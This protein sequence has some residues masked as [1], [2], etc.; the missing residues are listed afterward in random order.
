MEK[1]VMGK[2]A[3][4]G[5]TASAR[6]PSTRGL[7]FELEY[8]AVPGRRVL[9][10]V[11]TQIL[12]DKE[13]SAPP[14]LLSQFLLAL[15]LGKGV[16]GLL[17]AVGKKKLSADKLT[18]EIQEQ[19]LRKLKQASLRLDGT[20]GALLAD[21]AK[22]NLLVGAISFLPA[23]PAR[24]LVERLGLKE[25]LTLE[26]MPD[27]AEHG[28]E[29]SVAEVCRKLLLAMKLPAQGGVALCSSAETCQGALIAGLHCVAVPD[30]YTGHQDFS[31]GDLVLENLKELRLK[32]LLEMTNPCAFRSS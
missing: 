27:K 1:N 16:E 19:Y 4:A 6:E 11:V 26:V 31:G 14:V 12:K 25:A 30:E 7:V 29:P 23:D 5:K 22:A 13:I 8:L 15:P 24:E 9:F 3:D 21:A 20:L 18:A 10:E 2:P 32:V 17:G 28:R